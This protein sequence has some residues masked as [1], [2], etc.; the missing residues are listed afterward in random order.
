LRHKHGETFAGAAGFD[1]FGHR[2][3]VAAVA[4]LLQLRHELGRA[5][6]QNDVAIDHHG[7]T[8]KVHRLF[9]CDIDQ[10]GHVLP[11]CALPV[12]I[13]CIWKPKTTAVRQRT[14]TRIKVIKTRI[15]QLDRDG[16][17]TQ[18]FCYSAV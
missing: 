10:I 18:H 13:E 5:F 14:K 8:R 12:F 4:A 1:E 7:V 2:Q 3:L 9:R 15:D 6:G 17:A 16:K 11:E